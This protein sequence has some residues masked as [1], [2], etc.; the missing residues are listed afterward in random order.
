MKRFSLLLLMG[1]LLANGVGCAI[2]PNPY[3]Y[4][5][6]AFGGTYDRA[7]RTRSRVGSAFEPAEMQMAGNQNMIGEDLRAPEP[8]M[9]LPADEE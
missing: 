6:N 8:D 5:Y 7:D 3:D 9:P 4:D 1:L 2:C